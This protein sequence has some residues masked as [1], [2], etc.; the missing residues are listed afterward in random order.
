MPL[1]GQQTP[2]QVAINGYLG[3]DPA[4]MAQ[5]TSHVQRPP[6]NASPAQQLAAVQS[7]F[8]V[9]RHGG[10][11]GL[12]WQDGTGREPRSPSDTL[13]ARG[14]DCDEMSTLFYA[15]ARQLGIDVSGFRLSTMTLVSGG[16]RVEHAPL[17]LEM[18]GSKYIVDPVMPRIVPVRDFNDATL[19][20][21]L[22]PYF[23]LSGQGPSAATTPV[24]IQDRNDFTGAADIASVELLQRAVRNSLLGTSAG[25]ASARRDLER[26]AAIGSST[27]IITRQRD[28]VAQNLF[29]AYFNGADNAF[30]GGARGA[31]VVKGYS[32]ALAIIGLVPSIANANEARIYRTHGGLGLCFKSQGRPAEARAEFSAQ[33]RMRPADPVGYRNLINLE[34]GLGNRQGAIAAC[35][36]ALQG[37]P[38]GPD[39]N[40]IQAFRAQLVAKGTKKP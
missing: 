16:A 35:D 7:L 27:P 17:L 22:G 24:T 37:I 19:I 29:L 5:I 6:N 18:G 13:R 3:I 33:I 9:L 15:A 36:A 21:I 32:D 34:Y 20:G 4:L 38:Q 2:Q 11:L 23:H 1:M 12:R 25:T 10:T 31:P 28:T 30:T 14:G 26:I 39:Y 40:A 8:D